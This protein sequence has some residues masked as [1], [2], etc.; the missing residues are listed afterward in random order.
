MQDSEKIYCFVDGVSKNY[1]NFKYE[2]RSSIVKGDEEPIRSYLQSSCGFDKS[3]TAM[4]LYYATMWSQENIVKLLLDHGVDPNIPFE[5]DTALGS[6]ALHGYSKIALVLLEHGANVDGKRTTGQTP[7]LVA[8]EKGNLPF[9]K[10]LLQHGA[11]INATDDYGHGALYFA[12]KEG[13]VDIAQFLREQGAIINPTQEAVV[14]SSLNKLN[15]YKLFK[16][17]QSM[18]DLIEENSKNGFVNLGREGWPEPNPFYRQ[19]KQGLLLEYY[20]GHPGKLWT[21]WGEIMLV[22]GGWSSDLKA[23][24]DPLLQRL[25]LTEVVPGKQTESGYYGPIYKIEAVCGKPLPE[26]VVAEKYDDVAGYNAVKAAWKDLLKQYEEE[27][28]TLLNGL[29]KSK[30]ATHLFGTLVDPLNC[31]SKETLVHTAKNEL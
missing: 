1:E 11:N 14:M 9:A 20:Y 21:P 23:A 31:P 24:T 28:S 17:I 4:A 30:L 12:L 19:T 6:A 3:I 27:K 5:K 25:S 22:G 7:F 2:L 15:N 29:F 18:H 10:F 16:L 13:R 26:A 8:I